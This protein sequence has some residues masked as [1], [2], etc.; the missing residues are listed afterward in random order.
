MIIWLT[1]LKPSANARNLVGQQL[2]TFRTLMDVTYCVRLHTLVHVVVCCCAKYGTGR[3]FIR[4]TM[5]GVAASVCTPLPPP[6]WAGG[7]GTKFWCTF[8]SYLI[9][10]EN[11]SQFLTWRV[12][13]LRWSIMACFVRNHFFK[14]GNRADSSSLAVLAP[15]PAY[16]IKH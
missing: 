15:A 7:L 4:P 11:K 2:P 8:C 10:D 5:S 12:P 16:E 13:L 1:S 6:G 3:P 9:I 14:K